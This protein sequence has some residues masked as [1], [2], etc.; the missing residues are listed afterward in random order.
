VPRGRSAD[1]GLPPTVQKRGPPAT[2]AIHKGSKRTP[3][4]KRRAAALAPPLGSSSKRSVR[5]QNG[6]GLPPTQ[7]MGRSPVGAVQGDCILASALQFAV[8]RLDE[9]SP[10]L[11]FSH[12][13][14]AEPK[15]GRANEPPS[16]GQRSN[17]RLPYG[18]VFDLD[19][20]LCAAYVCTKRQRTRVVSR[21][22][23]HMMTTVFAK[24][25]SLRT[26]HG[27]RVRR[28]PNASVTYHGSDRPK[29]CYTSQRSPLSLCDDLY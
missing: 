9:L 2:W 11:P 5:L 22:G 15:D 27:K 29:I 16:S 12:S 17:V 23:R 4:W 26:L 10:I 13:F 21:S 20:S 14:R 8:G 6:M 24:P 3:E 25:L 7:P 19:G 18:T 28:M 1:G